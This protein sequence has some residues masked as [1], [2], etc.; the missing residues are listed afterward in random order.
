MDGDAFLGTD[1]IKRELVEP[2]RLSK[3]QVSIAGS[4]V[5]R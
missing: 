4:A 3:A 2:Y 5:L 1:L